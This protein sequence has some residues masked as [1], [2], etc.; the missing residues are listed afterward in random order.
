[1][2]KEIEIIVICDENGNERLRMPS[3]IRDLFGEILQP[4][5]DAEAIDHHC[6]L[7]PF[8]SAEDFKDFLRSDD[9]LVAAMNAVSKSD[10]DHDRMLTVAWSM[11]PDWAKSVSEFEK[12]WKLRIGNPGL[13]VS[14]GY[15]RGHVPSVF[16]P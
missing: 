5:A 13:Y 10:E 1:M 16:S 15:L 3:S 6:G 8:L 2:G 7:A 14:Y 11:L 4:Y 12:R 9:E